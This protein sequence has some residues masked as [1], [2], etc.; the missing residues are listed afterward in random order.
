MQ[1][2]HVLRWIAA[3]AGQVKLVASVCTG[4]FLL[5]RAGMITTQKVTTH[6]QDI[7]ELAVSTVRQMGF[8]WTNS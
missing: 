6:W 7:A 4:A 1:K 3:V 8:G 2:P 5:A